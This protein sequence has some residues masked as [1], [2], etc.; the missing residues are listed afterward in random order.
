M[1][2]NRP[3]PIPNTSDE[4][5][6]DAVRNGDTPVLTTRGVADALPISRRAVSN[7]LNRLHDEGS[8]EKMDVGPKAKV[9]WVEDDGEPL[10]SS[11]VVEVPDEDELPG[12]NAS[13]EELETAIDDV[14]GTRGRVE[15]RRQRMVRVLNKYDEDERVCEY[16]QQEV[17]REVLEAIRDDQ[18][19]RIE[20][21]EQLKERLEDRLGTTVEDRDD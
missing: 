3:G 12:P 6:I 20:E 8:I 15:N 14:V 1:A 10:Q 2:K 11:E 9:W 21:L 4:E 19:E 13:K 5:I 7:R 18:E 16:C 17:E